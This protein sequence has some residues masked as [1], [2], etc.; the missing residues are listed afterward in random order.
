[1]TVPDTYI[2]GTQ[3][4]EQQRLAALNR[5][6][7]RAFIEFLDIQPAMQVLEVGSG[8]GLLAADVASATANVQVVGLE[9][10]EA[11]IAA[12]VKAVGV[13]Y[14]QGDAHSLR[15]EDERFDLVYARYLL[16]HVTAP[17][18]VLREMRRV[19]RRGGRVA[20]CEN[21]VTLLRLDPAC[22]AF[23]RL[24]QI[25]QEHQH[26]LGGDSHIGRSLYRLFH[27]AGFSTVELSV[28]PEVHWHGSVAFSGWIQNVIGNIESAR[29]GMVD[30]G[31]CD[32][33]HVDKA[34]AEL[35]AFSQNG[36][37]SSHF[38]W[39]RAVAVR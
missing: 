17:V 14:V 29:R 8:L 39:N 1:M 11:Q 33:L 28:Q 34:V 32:E 7:N 3:P 37:A 35:V 18:D 4:D 22:P 13:R 36:D 5:L 15:F 10:S 21:D 38:M 16:E 26:N 23:E 2:H 9:R 31:L 24:W 30:S 20:A 19:A 25:F 6:T 12:A 27:H